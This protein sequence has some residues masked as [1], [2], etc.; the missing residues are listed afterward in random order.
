MRYRH[1]KSQGSEFHCSRQG[2]G[3]FLSP[4]QAGARKARAEG[5]ERR[6]SDLVETLLEDTR[7]SAP[8]KTTKAG[9]RQA[10]ASW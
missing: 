9:T 1:R 6:Q 3:D 8:E 4:R 10:K 5:L 7:D 2:H